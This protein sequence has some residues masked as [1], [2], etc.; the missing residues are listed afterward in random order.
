MVLLKDLVEEAKLKQNKNN[1]NRKYKRTKSPLYKKKIKGKPMETGFYGVYKLSCKYGE[2][3]YTWLY[4]DGEHIIYRND[5]F[6]LKNEVIRNGFKWE[7]ENRYM[8]FR[9]SRD[10]GY[11]LYDLIYK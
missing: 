7:L 9:T 11:P 1:K 10:V 5:F 3:K 8:A 6:E 4:D 2:D